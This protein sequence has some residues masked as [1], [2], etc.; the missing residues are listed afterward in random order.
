MG[1]GGRWGAWKSREIFLRLLR[2]PLLNIPSDIQEPS[3]ILFSYA[4]TVWT[5]SVL[6]ALSRE[7]GPDEPLWS[8]QPH[9]FR[10]SVPKFLTNK[11]KSL[12]GAPSEGGK[13]D[14]EWYRGQRLRVTHPLDK[15]KALARA[16]A[17]YGATTMAETLERG[18]TPE[19]SNSNCRG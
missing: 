18:Q 10:D 17:S 15:D 11:S 16:A 4:K 13:G 2:L 3:D 1:S 8:F 9:P 5:E 7:M 14:R 6:C 19:C 12:P